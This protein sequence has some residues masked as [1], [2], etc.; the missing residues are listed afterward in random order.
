MRTIALFL[1]GFCLCLPFLVL[2]HDAE[3]DATATALSLKETGRTPAGGSPADAPGLSIN[4]DWIVISSFTGSRFG[5]VVAGLGDVN[6]DGYGDVAVAAPD[7]TDGQAAEGAVFVYHGSALGPATDADWQFEP[8]RA[9]ESC[10]A[11]LAAGNLNGDAYNDLVVGAPSAQPSP[12]VQGV[13]YIFYGS[14]AGLSAAPSLTLTGNAFSES[15]GQSIAVGDVDQDGCDDLLV[16][17]PYY[18]EIQA[19]EGKVSL[20]YGSPTGPVSPAEWTFQPDNAG[21]WLG[22]GTAVVGDIDLDGY[23]DLAVGAPGMANGQ[24]EEGLVLIFYG[25]PSTPALFPDL[26]LESNQSYNHFGLT[27]SAAG[28]VDR[29]GYADLAVGSYEIGS[30][31][32]YRGS[33]QGLVSMPIWSVESDQVDAEFGYRVAGLGD[34]DGDG[35]N[36]LIV[37]APGLW[38]EGWAFAYLGMEGGLATAADWSIQCSQEGGGL[39]RGAAGA[40][41]VNGDGYADVIVGADH[42]SDDKAD[43]GAALI[44]FGACK[45]CEID[46]VC[47]LPNTVNPGNPCETCNPDL[48]LDGWSPRDTNENGEPV[49]CEDGIF[50]NGSDYCLDGVCDLHPDDPCPGDG[51]FCNGVETCNETLD[52]CERSGTPCLDDELWCNGEELCDEGNERCLQVNVPRCPDDELWCNGVEQCDEANDQCVR[53]DVPDCSDDGLWC[54]GVEICDEGNDQCLSINPPDCGDDGLWCNGNEFC[55]EGLNQCGSDYTGENPRCPDDG[56]YCNGEEY[57]NE[58]EDQCSAADVPDCEDDG[59]WCN[60]AESCDEDMDR[61]EHEFN[62]QTNPRCPDDGLF[63]DGEELCSEEEDQCVSTGDPCLETETVCNEEADSCDESD[64]D[65]DD[66]DNDNDTADDDDQSPG[67]TDDDD[68]DENGPVARGGDDDDSGSCGC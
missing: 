9:G 36:D 67:Q 44:Y 11:A 50:C 38:D 63:C 2:A 29:D 12:G 48:A 43:E 51:I 68:N 57:C 1:L 5:A 37:S 19:E 17:D 58:V 56:L 59:D 16:G 26:I 35:N 40:G 7:Y 24:V 8:D 34:V 23:G 31:V 41:D 64:D 61:C 32:V 42:L 65:D 60:G 15:F 20:F 14:A 62:N 13:V 18:S 45:G 30:A 52:M 55:D 46:H 47:Y 27:V 10:G 4:P 33:Y 54:N 66:D 21:A 6:G 25:S 28:D 22:F 53:V 3:V 39:G 49:P